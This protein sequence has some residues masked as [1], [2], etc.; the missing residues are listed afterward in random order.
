MRWYNVTL[1]FIQH[2][3]PGLRA[4]RQVNLALLSAAILSRRKLS[5]SVLARALP[6][7]LSL[8]HHHRKKRL[9]RFLSN[10]KL[11]PIHLQTEM[12][13]HIL[14]VAGIRGLIPFERK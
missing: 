11:D 6:V 14:S 9:F 7:S 2:T 5:L 3:I 8:A 12:M 13:A 10:D 1:S 4:T